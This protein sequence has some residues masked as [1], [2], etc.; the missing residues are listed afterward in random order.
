M[1]DVFGR[2]PAHR[3]V[4]L[5]RSDTEGILIIYN[6]RQVVGGDT[7]RVGHSCPSLPHQD[8]KQQ[9]T[10]TKSGYPLAISAAEH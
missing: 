2:N 5:G 10:Q 8:Q 7:C 1:Y 9:G 3:L 6:Q 4:T